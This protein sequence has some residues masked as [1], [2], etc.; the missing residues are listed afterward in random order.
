M[1]SVE[2][3]VKGTSGVLEDKHML[4]EAAAGS[5]LYWSQIW[6]CQQSRASALLWC[7]RTRV[8]LL[9]RGLLLLL[10]LLAFGSSLLPLGQFQHLPIPLQ[11]LL[12]G[13]RLCIH[14]RPDHTNLNKLLTRSSPPWPRWHQWRHLSSGLMWW[15]CGWQGSLMTA[16]GVCLV[17]TGSSS[18][19][20]H[21]AQLF[22]PSLEKYPVLLVTLS[23]CWCVRENVIN[24]LLLR[25]LRSL[26]LHCHGKS[27]FGK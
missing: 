24:L 13:C 20:G 2:L 6:S 12:A 10:K 1:P 23:L 22:P 25:H 15:D 4:K 16:L 8:M 21:K 26:I 19:Q 27:I 3:K 14:A 11:Q 18:F 9:V 17:W 7:F 5:Q